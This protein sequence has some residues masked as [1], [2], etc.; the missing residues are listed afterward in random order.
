M[1]YLSNDDVAARHNINSE[2]YEKTKYAYATR[3]FTNTHVFISPVSFEKLTI[4]ANDSCYSKAV[5]HL[6]LSTDGVLNS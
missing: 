2:I 1:S 6:T 4:I 5:K 3:F